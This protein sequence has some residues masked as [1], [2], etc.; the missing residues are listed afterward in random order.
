MGMF[1]R[2]ALM[3]PLIVFAVPTP[4]CTIIACGLPVTMA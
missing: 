1:V 3:R 2:E 4:T